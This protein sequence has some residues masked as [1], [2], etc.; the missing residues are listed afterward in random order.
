MDHLVDQVVVVD[1]VVFSRSILVEWRDAQCFQLLIFN[2]FLHVLVAA[3]NLFIFFII[4]FRVDI[5][6][7][8]EL[9]RL[10]QQ[11]FIL[12]LQLPKLLLHRIRV[13]NPVRNHALEVTVILH[14]IL[15][16]LIF[17]DLVVDQLLVVLFRLR[18]LPVE[19]GL[20]GLRLF[21]HEVNL[22]L[23][24]DLEK[25]ELLELFAVVVAGG[26]QS[27]IRIFPCV[28]HFRLLIILIFEQVVLLFQ[29][30]VDLPLDHASLVGLEIL[31]LFPSFGILSHKLL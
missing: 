1:G 14:N 16:L 8:F 2:I 10:M 15:I 17:S 3:F 23:E 28:Q 22:V 31:Q 19:A 7:L 29:R 24:L 6:C 25:F 30:C 4:L 26:L 27:A 20:E 12:P 9:G 11:L 18:F 5:S 13:L 21:L